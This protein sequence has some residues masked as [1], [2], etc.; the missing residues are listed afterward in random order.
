[1]AEVYAALTTVEG[2]AG[3]WTTNT[4]GKGNDLGG[5]LQ[6]RFEAGGFD[7]KVIELAPGRRVL[8]EGRSGP[9]RRQDRQLELTIARA[10]A[11]MVLGDCVA[12]RRLVLCGRQRE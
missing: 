5:V 12:H 1:V 11:V 2:L 10:G 9:S 4:Q 8:W 6:F 7:M 3:W